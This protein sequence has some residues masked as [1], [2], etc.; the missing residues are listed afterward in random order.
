MDS[1]GDL[2]MNRL[3]AALPDAAPP[4]ERDAARALKAGLRRGDPAALRTF[5]EQAMRPLY[6]FCFFKLGRDHHATEEVVQETLVRALEVL[7]DWDPDRGDLHTWI[8]FLSRNAIRQQNEARR[9]F[10]ATAIPEKASEPFVE[11]ELSRAALV[12][13][14]LAR[15]PA[16]YRALL[17]RRYFKGDSVRAIAQEHRTTEKAVE[18][19][20][21]R[22]REAFRHQF[23]AITPGTEAEK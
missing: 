22:A 21:A 7:E 16:H 1:R 14:A 20:L 4:Q 11:D 9:R 13:V 2:A 18:S 12:T 23:I 8:A 19:L 15:L 6:T 3:L 17:D 5:Y 10:I